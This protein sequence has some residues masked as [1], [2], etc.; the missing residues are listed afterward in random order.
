MEIEYSGER[1]GGKK[2]RKKS[3]EKKDN[4]VWASRPHCN[5]AREAVKAFF[6]SFILT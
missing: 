4:V 2:V 6:M 3:K 1:E 5:G